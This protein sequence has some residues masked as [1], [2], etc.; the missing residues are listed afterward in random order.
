MMA[1][2]DRINA[3]LRTI[4]TRFTAHDSDTARQVSACLDK[5]LEGAPLLSP[6]R[7]PVCDILQEITSLADDELMRLAAACL[8]DLHWKAPG[9][10][11]LPNEVSGNMAAAE[12]IG[13]NGMYPENELRFGLLLQREFI[14]YPSHRHAAEELYFVLSGT[15]NWAV[16]D[17]SPAPRK[18]GSFVHH[19]PWQP[20][21]ITTLK[22]PILA[23]W[24][25]T[26]DIGATS[27]SC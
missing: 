5:G 24:C 7:V 6:A 14:N 13:P 25:W 11:K 1:A 2:T 12:I 18:P 22:Q 19:K 26:G 9:F 4:W 20:H 21:A 10:G 17:Q 27:Y 8:D 16:D 15:A 3:F 23:A